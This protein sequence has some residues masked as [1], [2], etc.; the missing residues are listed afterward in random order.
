M[1]TN[2]KEV[3]FLKIQKSYFSKGGEK[4]IIAYVTNIDKK[5]KLLSNS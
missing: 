3:R 1:T 5:D 2:E 4:L